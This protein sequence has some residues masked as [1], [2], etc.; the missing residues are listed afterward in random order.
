MTTVIECRPRCES[1]MPDFGTFNINQH[2]T[3]CRDRRCSIV[4]SERAHRLVPDLR[5]LTE[6][7]KIAVFEHSTLKIALTIAV[8]A[9]HLILAAPT[10]PT[11][12]AS[13]DTQF[14]STVTAA[15]APVGV[16]WG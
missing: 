1:V 8:G 16:G 14:P 11:C 13:R 5:R 3:S 9:A 7:A 4:L 15:P 10:A 12:F 2:G 6:I